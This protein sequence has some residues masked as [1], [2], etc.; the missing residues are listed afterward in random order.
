MTI[1][2]YL[3]H[4][5]WPTSCKHSFKYQPLSGLSTTMYFAIEPSVILTFLSLKQSSNPFHCNHEEGNMVVPRFDW[6]MNWSTKLQCCFIPHLLRKKRLME[7][8]WGS[9]DCWTASLTPLQFLKS[10][11]KLRV[12]LSEGGDYNH[13]RYDHLSI[14]LLAYLLLPYD[15]SEEEFAVLLRRLHP[16]SRWA[17]LW[18]VELWTW[19]PIKRAWH[20]HFL[21]CWEVTWLRVDWHLWAW[22]MQTA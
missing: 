3:P 20:P 12:Y 14:D 10:E 22:E 19:A 21:R 4:F 17:H 15:V 16:W 8:K 9:E 2:K 5:P 1:F 11:F 18:C 13:Q 6:N 7:P